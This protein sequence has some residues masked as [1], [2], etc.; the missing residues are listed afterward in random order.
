VQYVSCEHFDTMSE[1]NANL[2][3]HGR[4]FVFEGP[5]DVGKTTLATIL[6]QYLTE[7]GN[8]SQSLSFPGS[9]PGTLGELV[10]RLYSDPSN[11]GVPNVSSV[12]MQLVIT[13]AH[14]ETI[15]SRIKPL[16]RAGID[17]VLDRFWWSTWVYA[18]V[19]G[20]PE[21]LI[22]KMIQLELRVWEE[23]TP[24]CVFLILRE[25]P[26]LE[27]SLSHPW[28]SILAHYK[29]LFKNQQY[30]GRNHLVVNDGTIND[31]M[32]AVIS[33]MG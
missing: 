31:A 3:K 30:H 10:Y 2:R 6:T 21:D 18:R 26:F 27:Q 9:E 28:L 14:V 29:Q 13:A 11:F 12:A 24:T 15:E 8:E 7:E 20:V 25:T 5:N 16:I 17:V 19:E 1:H 32:Q 22:E 33:H 23:I 4:L